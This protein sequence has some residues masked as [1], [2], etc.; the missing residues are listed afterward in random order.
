M[1]PMDA[2][3]LSLRVTIFGYA[4]VEH[5]KAIWAANSPQSPRRAP[6]YKY[7]LNPKL[8]SP[9]DDVAFTVNNDTIYGGCALDLRAEPTV[10]TAPE[11]ENAANWLP[12]GVHVRDGGI[13]L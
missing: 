3:E 2:R 11:G 13:P 1:N 5:Y 12:A 9:D 7:S 6:A 4:V 10:L 8:H